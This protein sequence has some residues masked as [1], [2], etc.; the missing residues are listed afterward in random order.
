M[1]CPAVNTGILMVMR[2]NASWSMRKRRPSELWAALEIILHASGGHISNWVTR[3]FPGRRHCLYGDPAKLMS[4]ILFNKLLAG[5]ADCRPYL[6]YWRMEGLSRWRIVDLLV[7]GDFFLRMP[8]LFPG[9]PSNLKLVW[10]LFLAFVNHRFKIGAFCL[11]S[12]I[13]IYPPLPLPLPSSLVPPYSFTGPPRASVY[14]PCIRPG[15]ETP[16]Y[17][18]ADQDSEPALPA[19]SLPTEETILLGKNGKRWHVLV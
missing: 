15:E 11:K 14:V 4:L 5:S 19:K 18:T 10:N 2:P 8:L 9:L 3:N 12:V 1:V 17:L 16:R 7:G 13:L 6:L